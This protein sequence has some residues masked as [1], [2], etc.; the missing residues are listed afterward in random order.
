LQIKTKPKDLCS[1]LKWRRNIYVFCSIGI[2]SS[3]LEHP[4]KIKFY[5]SSDF[6]NIFLTGMVHIKIKKK[7]KLKGKENL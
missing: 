3:Y 6:K 1:T 5:I 2:S 7:K 4:L